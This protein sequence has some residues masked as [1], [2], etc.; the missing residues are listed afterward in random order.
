MDKKVAFF[1]F[2]AI[3]SILGFAIFSE[4]RSVRKRIMRSVSPPLSRKPMPQW[5]K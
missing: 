3:A 1:L 4:R 5:P 2:V